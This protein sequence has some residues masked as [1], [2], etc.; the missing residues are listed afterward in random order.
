MC[1]RVSDDLYARLKARE[2]KLIMLVKYVIKLNVINFNLHIW[3]ELV[4][5]YMYL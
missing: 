2:N 5:R 1:I 4:K 3:D